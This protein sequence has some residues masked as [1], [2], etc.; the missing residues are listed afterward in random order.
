MYD[1]K[2]CKRTFTLLLLIY[3]RFS[4]ASARTDIFIENFIYRYSL[5]F[6]HFSRSFS[7]YMLYL[8]ERCPYH[9][10]TPIESSA[11]VLFSFFLL[12]HP[13]R[14]AYVVLQ[15]YIYIYPYWAVSIYSHPYSIHI[16]ELNYS[17]VQHDNVAVMPSGLASHLLQ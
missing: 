3:R 15:L 13:C 10:F 16:L 9:P 12:A 6:L 14:Y 5:S 2:H 8:L 1:N 4:L 7:F 17:I 11:Q